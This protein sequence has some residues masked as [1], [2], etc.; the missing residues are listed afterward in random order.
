MAAETGPGTNQGI[1]GIVEEATQLRR[2]LWINLGVAGSSA[3]A[4]SAIEISHIFRVHND[5]LELA[6][7]IGLI[8]LGVKGILTV[9]SCEFQGQ[10][11]D[12]RA[13]TTAME[14]F[15]KRPPT[16]SNGPQSV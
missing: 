10:N 13:I 3:L 4:V 14:E 11:L 8:A 2:R 6:I 12:F 7:E 16:L 5:P 15:S 1:Q 9:I